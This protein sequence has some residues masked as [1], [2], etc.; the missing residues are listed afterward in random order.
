MD[1]DFQ[2]REDLSDYFVQKYIEYSGDAGLPR[3]LN[4]YK[5]YR[6]YIRA[7]VIGF[8]ILDESVG[9]EE[10]NES[11]KLTAKYVKLALLYSSKL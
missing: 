6:A 8:K 2:G 1:L 9:D 11:K 3:L 4:F 5:S 10:K 7:K